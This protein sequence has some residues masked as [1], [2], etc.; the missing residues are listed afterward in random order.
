MTHGYF[1]QFF[2]TAESQHIYFAFDACKIGDF[3][4]LVETNRV[5]AFASDNSYSYDGTGDIDNGVFTY[6]QML[7]WDSYTTF[8]DDANY[9]VQGMEDWAS[10]YSINVDP[11]YVDQFTGAMLP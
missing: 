3:Q 8:E 10:Y 5:G 9:A 11:F 1:E 6:Y 4:G 7:G 2:D